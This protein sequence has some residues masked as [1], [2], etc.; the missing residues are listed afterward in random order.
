MKHIFELR[1]KEYSSDQI[2][3]AE[4]FYAV[5]DKGLT[6]QS[7]FASVCLVNFVSSIK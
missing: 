1:V 3:M 4:V 5:H 7:S 2:K 6:F